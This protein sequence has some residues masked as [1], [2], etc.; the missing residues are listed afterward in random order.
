MREIK[1]RAYDI[2]TKKMWQWEEHNA[3]TTSKGS[4]KDWFTDHDLRPMQYT[5][6]KDINGQ[7][8][9]EGDFLDLGID[10]NDTEYIAASSEFGEDFPAYK[11]EFHIFAEVVWDEE[12]GRWEARPWCIT[13]TT[14]EG[15]TKS[16]PLDIASGGT[17]DRVYDFSYV[18][19][20]P[21]VGNIYNK[22]KSIK[23][24]E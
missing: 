12:E 7:E 3:F 15:K 16:T 22:P 10:P 23:E 14:D 8:I 20:Y 19:N 1:F 2:F 24:A 11:Q 9:Y 17:D 6:F 4:I 18:S 5:G 21:V 13:L